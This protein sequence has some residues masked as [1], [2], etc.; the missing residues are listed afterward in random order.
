MTV[1]NVCT[2]SGRFA[3]NKDVARDLRTKSL[4]PALARGEEVE[5]NFADVEL[6]TQSFV[7]ALISDVVRSEAFDAL[8]LMTF[9]NCNDAVRALIELVVEYSQS[10]IS[11]A[12]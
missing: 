6:T 4:M 7:H 3:E 12:D 8:D 10:D 9:S 2:A 11:V 5:L 1:I